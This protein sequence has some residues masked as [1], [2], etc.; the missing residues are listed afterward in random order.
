MAI[1]GGRSDHNY[2]YNIIHEIVRPQ[3]GMTVI[4]VNK[5]DGE[6]R[7]HGGFTEV[8]RC[9]SIEHILIR[10]LNSIPMWT[11]K[12]IS[13]MLFKVSDTRKPI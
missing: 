2:M 4:Q 3:V 6:R 1:V 5:T 13:Q 8:F 9:Y 11:D 7:A 12:A 10:E